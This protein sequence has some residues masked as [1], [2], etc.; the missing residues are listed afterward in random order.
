[1]KKESA[2]MYLF[3][4]PFAIAG[5]FCGYMGVNQ[6]LDH[7]YLTKHGIE[8]KGIVVKLIEDSK[9]SSSVKPIIEFVTE[10]G[11]RIIHKSNYATNIN[12]AKIGDET[13]VW[14]DPTNTKN[15]LSAFDAPSWFFFIFLLT[16]GGIGIGGIIYLTK[17]RQ[18]FDW[19]QTNGRVI[20]ASYKE[21]VVR[22]DGYC[23]KATWT[24]PMTK[25]HYEFSCD[26][27]NGNYRKWTVNDKISVLIDPAN[28]KR[29]I[30][31][32]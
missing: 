15:H 14:Y 22:G 1:M 19:L 32:L 28:P 16:H 13:T 17:K 29:Y 11:E 30:V 23:V 12:P 25:I 10:Q 9:N 21:T 7:Q 5:L 8:T 4:I 26:A 31:D 24:D 27:Y 18:F 3:Y 2:W 20:Q 6:I